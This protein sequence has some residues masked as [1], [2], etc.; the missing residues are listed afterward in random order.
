MVWCGRSSWLEVALF[1]PAHPPITIAAAASAVAARMQEN[2]Q[3]KTT[4]LTGDPI[5]LSA[6]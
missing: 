2:E 1:A 3:L 6:I 5:D 4:P